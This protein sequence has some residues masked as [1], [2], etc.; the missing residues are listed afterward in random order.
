MI[1]CPCLFCFIY[2]LD[3]DCGK[4]DWVEFEE[5]YNQNRPTDD[6]C[7]SH[8]KIKLRNT[9]VS[10][11]FSTAT[12][13]NLDDFPFARDKIYSKCTSKPCRSPVLSR[14]YEEAYLLEGGGV[15]GCVNGNSCECVK[16]FG[17]TL[18]RFQM[19]NEAEIGGM[20]LLC[21]RN[22]VLK[23]YI[24]AKSNGIIPERSIQPYRNIIGVKG[25]YT[26]NDCIACDD[27]H[28]I[29][30]FVLHVANKYSE[31]VINGV[32]RVIQSGYGDFGLPP[33]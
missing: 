25:E 21:V 26:I 15:N 19:P 32:H 13:C 27:G 24:D 5:I 2:M 22:S 14:S 17:F 9:K 20:C 7:S 31:T 23:L 16:M 28:R 30:P 33:Q 6:S 10:V 12:V 11:P 4:M 3:S 18:R 1:L 29:E 8:S